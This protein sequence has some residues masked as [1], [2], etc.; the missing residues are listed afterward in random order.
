MHY[1]TTER[2][3]SQC[4]VQLKLTTKK[5]FAKPLNCSIVKLCL[6]HVHQYCRICSMSFTLV[7]H[8]ITK[9][10]LVHRRSSAVG[11]YC[12]VLSP[13]YPRFSPRF[14]SWDESRASQAPRHKGSKGSGRSPSNFKSVNLP[15][16][17]STKN[18]MSL[19]I[20]FQSFYNNKD[21]TD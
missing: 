4:V 14:S 6:C 3:L 11:A 1:L 8:F 5:M 10:I 19:V 20:Q 21:M 7:V 15:Y 17:E 12:A 2:D 18:V 13:W 16:F 9:S